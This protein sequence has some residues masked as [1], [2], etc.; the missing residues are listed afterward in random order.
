MFGVER[1]SVEKLMCVGGFKECPGLKR[2]IPEVIEMF[3]N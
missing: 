1:G 3:K 2:A